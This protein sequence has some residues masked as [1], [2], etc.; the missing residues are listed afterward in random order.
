MSYST[1]SNYFVIIFPFTEFIYVAFTLKYGILCPN[2]DVI[3]PVNVI[4]TNGNILFVIFQMDPINE[5]N[6]QFAF[7]QKCA[8][9]FQC[10]LYQKGGKH[11][12][13]WSFRGRVICVYTV[14]LDPSIR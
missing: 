9:D 11:C 14:C 12:I 6:S 5:I 1:K 7:T 3:K 8:R 4:E 13:S 10:G 2:D